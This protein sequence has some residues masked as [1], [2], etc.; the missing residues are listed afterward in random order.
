MGMLETL[1]D[2]HIFGCALAKALGIVGSFKVVD[3]IHEQNKKAESK[4]RKA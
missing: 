3:Y 2:F 4:M 1:A